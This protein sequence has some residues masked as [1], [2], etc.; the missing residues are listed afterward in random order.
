MKTLSILFLTLIAFTL[1]AQSSNATLSWDKETD[2]TIIGYH[3][4]EGV[5]SRTYTNE[6]DV[7]S[8]TTFI[9]SNLV[10]NVKYF[11]S[12]TAYNVG[13]LESDYSAEVNYTYSPIPSITNNPPASVTNKFGSTVVITAGSIGGLNFHWYKNSTI[14]LTNGGN[15]SGV[16]TSTLMISNVSWLD[17]GTYSLQVSNTAGAVFS[18]GETVY[19]S[20]PPVSNVRVSSGP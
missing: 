5:S 15:L 6:F 19:V 10:A 9:V 2:P 11:F 3:V 17:N 1:R 20:P 7:G 8:A 4:Y 14:A 18:S 13:G 16:L 12:V